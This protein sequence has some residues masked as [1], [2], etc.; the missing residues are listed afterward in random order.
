M[1]GGEGL[2]EVGTGRGVGVVVGES[3]TSGG[4]FA[5]CLTFLLYEIN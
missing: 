3:M 2:T 4:V 1:D 5:K